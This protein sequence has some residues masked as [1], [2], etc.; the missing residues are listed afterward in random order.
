MAK[1]KQPTVVDVASRAG[2]AVGTVSRV[3]NHSEAVRQGTRDAV[4]RAITDLGFRPNNVARSM[5]TRVTRTVGFV[6]P[7]ISNPVFSLIAREAEQVLQSEDY[8]LNVANSG[9]NVE[10]EVRLVKAFAERQC[11]ALILVT[12][13]ESDPRVLQALRSSGL[14]VLALDREID[15]DIDRVMIDHAHGMRLATDYLLELGHKRIAL[16]N[17]PERVSPGRQRSRGF[18]DAHTRRGVKLDE[19]LVRSGR[20]DQDFGAAQVASLL[21]L[22]RPPTAIIAGG[23]QILVGVLQTLQQR[24][25]RFP[26]DISLIGCDDTPV[27][28]VASPPITIVDRDLGQIGRTA[29]RIILDRLQNRN[30]PQPAVVA[31]LPTELRI[32]G[33]CASAR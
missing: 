5:R 11:D 24:R 21:D 19:A 15:L 4:W 14:P 26:R 25:L 29:A 10:R 12:N 33:S 9:D 30:A 28:Q 16:I 23:N 20:F 13:S 32:R 22:A 3:I 27:A 8:M 7:D 17:I 2:V 1:R 31:T 18:R 6:I